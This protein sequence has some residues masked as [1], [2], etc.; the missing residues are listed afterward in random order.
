MPELPYEERVAAAFVEL[1]DTLVRDLG[2]SGLLYVLAAHCVDLLDV[3]AAGVLLGMPQGRGVEVGASDECTQA[4]VRLGVE[5]DEGPCRDC[6]QARA[7]VAEV[8]LDDGVAD[9][10][11]PRFAPAARR[12]GFTS[13]AA[14]PLRRQDHAVGALVLFRSGPGTLDGGGLRLAQALADVAT[15][16][17]LQQRTVHELITL[18]AQLQHALDSRV[19]I[20][21]AKGCLAQRHDTTLD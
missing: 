19:V 14:V 11:W 15:I 8:R 4:L 13:V 21:Q 6:C 9:R 12:L 20:E 3:A 17:V 16:G 1:A 18:V 7:P 10:C 5:Q 2:V